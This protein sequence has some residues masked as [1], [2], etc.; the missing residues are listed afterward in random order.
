MAKDKNLLDGVVKFISAEGFV[1]ALQERLLAHVQS[2]CTARN[3]AVGDLPRLLDQQVYALMFTCVVED[4][5]GRTLAEGRNLTDAYL[6][7]HGWKLGALARRQLEAVRDSRIGLYEIDAVS[8]GV[9]L[10]LRDLLPPGEKVG[11]EAVALSRA[12]PVGCALAARVLRVDG[13][14]SLAGG[15]LP[16]D[17]GMSAEAAEAVAGAADR[18]EGITAFWLEENA[19]GEFWSQGSGARGV[20]R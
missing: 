13:T 7:R 3:L 5:M 2:T 20:A 19:G 11:V 6:K 18:T 1:D 10:T 9:G 14:V 12:L 4:L 15:L 17:E 8:V 16:F